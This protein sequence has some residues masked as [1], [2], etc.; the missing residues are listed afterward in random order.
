MGQGNQE[1]NSEELGDR[2]DLGGKQGGS[3]MHHRHCRWS[4]TSG[5]DLSVCS[6][7]NVVLSLC[8]YQLVKLKPLK[9]NPI[10]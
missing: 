5:V 1:D 3:D 8:F 7:G 10:I 2:G 9:L 4:S 6:Q